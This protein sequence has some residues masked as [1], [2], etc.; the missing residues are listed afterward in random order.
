MAETGQLVQWNDERGFGFIEGSDG[1]R[2][3]V[4]ISAIGRICHATPHWGPRE[5]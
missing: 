2:H 5:I 4:H 1:G 3:F